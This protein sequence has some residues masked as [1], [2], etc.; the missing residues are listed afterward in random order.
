MWIEI[1]KS[2][3]HMVS[4][5]EANLN[6]VGSI[7]IDEDLMEAA[8]LIEGEK[9]HVLNINNGERVETYVIKGERHSGSITL[10][11]PAARKFIPGD[12]IIVMSYAMMEFNEAKKFKPSIVFPDTNSNKLIK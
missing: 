7:G 11:G 10:N 2:K 1:L 8:N 9:V 5:T 3:I 12:V 4:V 6:Y